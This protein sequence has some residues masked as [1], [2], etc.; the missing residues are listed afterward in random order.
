VGAKYL[1]LFYAIAAF[2][3]GAASFGRYQLEAGSAA[4]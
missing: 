1:D 2:L 4:V 3:F